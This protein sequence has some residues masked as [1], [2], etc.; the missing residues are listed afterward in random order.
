M[1]NNMTE[2]FAL[3]LR[4]VISH[5]K[6]N[7]S[8]RH[9]SDI[10]KAHGITSIPQELFYKYGLDALSDGDTPRLS[11]CDKILDDIRGRKIKSK[12]KK[13]EVEAEPL[14]KAG[15]VVSWENKNGVKAIAYIGEDDVAWFTLNMFCKEDEAKRMYTN[16]ELPR[17]VVNGNWKVV[18]ITKEEYDAFISE[19]CTRLQPKYKDSRIH[20][21]GNLF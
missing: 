2:R 11:L 13:I 15:Q 18:D 21:Q 3:Y 17:E 8:L 7:G 20:T 12:T 6:K 1:K 5:Y 10:A 14:F 4:D 9:F 16:K 19:L